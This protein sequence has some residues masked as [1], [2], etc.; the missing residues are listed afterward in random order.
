MLPLPQ[1]SKA[2]ILCLGLK[3]QR[4]C[5]RVVATGAAILFFP[6]VTV[7]GQSPRRESRRNNKDKIWPGHGR[8]PRCTVTRTDTTTVS[9]KESHGSSSKKNH[10]HNIPLHCPGHGALKARGCGN[11]RLRISVGAEKGVSPE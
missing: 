9:S 5:I 8:V 10:T 7:P 11:L 3:P 2:G 6:P 4:A 1:Q